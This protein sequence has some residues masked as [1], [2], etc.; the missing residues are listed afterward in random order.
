MKVPIV[1]VMPTYACNISCEHCFQSYKR[2]NG[3]VDVLGIDQIAKIFAIMSEEGGA[4]PDLS[5]EWYGGEISLLGADYLSQA[6]QSVKNIFPKSSH[7]VVSNLIN[8]D[9][10]W[11]TVVYENCTHL[12]TSY[13]GIRFNSDDHLFQI[14][15][16]NVLKVTKHLTVDCIATQNPY[17]TRH[18]HVINDLPIQCISVVRMMVPED[19][20]VTNKKKI[21]KYTSCIDS[22]VQSC[23]EAAL[24]FGADRVEQTMH[25]G[26][27]IINGAK[28]F[29]NGDVG[30]PGP[31]KLGYPYEKNYIF[32]RYGVDNDILKSQKRIE[33]IASQLLLCKEHD[34]TDKICLAEFKY[35]NFCMGYLPKNH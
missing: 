30:L 31:S 13:E 5:V 6:I 10:K 21:L 1:N 35:P 18:F 25:D 19:M 23:K 11:L 32:Y 16:A 17:L 34:C 14:W 2:H 12:C 20:P 26:R 7:S 33:Y 15:V 22:Y 29:P 3:K 9:D 27:I 4:P 24:I 28:V 8:V